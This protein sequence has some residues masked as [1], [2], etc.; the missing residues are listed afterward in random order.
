M[1]TPILYTH[2]YIYIYAYR[3]SA[4]GRPVSSLTQCTD[5]PLEHAPSYLVPG[6]LNLHEDPHDLPE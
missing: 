5:L 1:Y 3:D 2:I 6:I 4:V